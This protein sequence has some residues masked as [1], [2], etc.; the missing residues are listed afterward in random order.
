VNGTLTA[1]NV[2]PQAGQGIGAGAFADVVDA[3]KNNISYANVH[4]STF[5]GGEIRGVVTH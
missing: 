4:T 3:M 1:A 2:F 5:P